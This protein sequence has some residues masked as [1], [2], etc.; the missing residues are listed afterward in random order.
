MPKDTYRQEG[1]R[2]PSKDTV[3]IKRI[4]MRLD[5]HYA[6]DAEAVGQDASPI[7]CSLW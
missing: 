1:R 6:V 7:A 2:K 4:S 3:Y 5:L